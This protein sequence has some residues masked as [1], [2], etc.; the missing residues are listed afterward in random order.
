MLLVI[1]FIGGVVSG[2]TSFGFALVVVPLLTLYMPAKT[3]VTLSLLLSNIPRI[4][5]IIE[6]RKWMKIKQLFPLLISGVIGV[7]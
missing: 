7:K 4:V 1:I 2:L 3:A 6:T 5:L